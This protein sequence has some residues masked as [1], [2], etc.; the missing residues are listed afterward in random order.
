LEKNSNVAKHAWELSYKIDFK[1]GKII[2]RGNYRIRKTI[3]SWHTA[4]IYSADN[5]SK[6]L[7]EQYSILLKKH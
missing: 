6:H 3:E 2:D 5:N 4:V 1:R 7:P